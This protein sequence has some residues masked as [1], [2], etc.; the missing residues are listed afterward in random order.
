MN[1][2]RGNYLDR[3][4]IQRG[5]HVR[6]ATIPDLA[7]GLRA[8]EADG[9][10]EKL[11]AG[12]LEPDLV[13]LDELGFTPLDPSLADAF[14]RII[15]S[16]YGRKSLIVTSNKSFES[17]AE[18]LPDAVIASAVLDRLVHHAHIVPIVGDSY[19]TKDVA[20]SRQPK[21]KPSSPPSESVS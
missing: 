13:I 1:E 9:T 7:A 8:A 17:W 3:R 2:R 4:R 6:F 18:V 21:E 15:A 20:D 5:Y 11:V 14:Y 19:R 12:L 16:R 10:M